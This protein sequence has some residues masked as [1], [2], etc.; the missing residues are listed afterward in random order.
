MIRRFA[1]AFLRRNPR[2]DTR[3][4]AR[5]HEARH[6]TI[7]AEERAYEEVFEFIEKLA[8]A[9]HRYGYAAPAI[10]DALTAVSRRL[11]VR[12]EFFA[13][14]TAI[15]AT[16]DAP[17]QHDTVLIRVEPGNVN[18]DKLSRLDRV[19][20]DVADGK[21]PPSEASRLI[22]E[23]RAT[24]PRY[25][26]KTTVVAAVVASACSA[27]F[28]GGGWREV[29]TCGV[30]GCISGLLSLVARRNKE[31]FQ[32]FE[33]VA[34]FFA[35]VIACVAAVLLPP[36]SLFI[37]TC[38]GLIILLPGLTVTT[39]ISE[40]A[41]QHLASGTARMM[42]ALMVFL[43]IGFGLAVG[44]KLGMVT[45]HPNIE[46]TSVALPA[47]TLFAALVLAP[48]GFMARF[49]A[50]PRDAVP[51]VLIC[52]LAFGCSRLGAQLMG[53]ANGGFA[54]ALAVGVA[55]GLYSRWRGQPALV[56]STV[57]II[58]LVPGSVGFRSIT[59]IIAKDPVA[60]IQTA[61][62]MVVVAV[63]IVTGLLLARV[64]VPRRTWR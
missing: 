50:H 3:A 30:I 28:F 11:G 54:G 6:D 45:M 12:G 55:S 23:I 62:T 2:P 33:P 59:N 19:A 4:I 47:W 25:R 37:A 1:S 9:L 51:I 60:G 21:I 27:R 26:G 14:P 15:L 22:D 35:G 63:A 34:A 10:E 36:V 24:P 31:R 13:T 39:A 43:T 8:R 56:T 17:D 42:S 46:A 40:L 29:V 7:S 49:Q 16:L 58:M 44:L 38:A 52:A 48:L 57:G 20:H 32:L 64:I 53:V 61:L 41:T 18:L 5:A